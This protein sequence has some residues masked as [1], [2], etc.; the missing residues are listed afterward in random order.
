MN[1]HEAVQLT[2]ESLDRAIVIFDLDLRVLT[3]SEH[4]ETVDRGRLAVILGRKATPQAAEMIAAS[5]VRTSESPVLLAAH[6]DV[7]ARVVVPLRYK[8]R[9]YG[10]LTFSQP[11]AEHI[12]DISPEFM[13][14]LT[15]AATQLA[16]LVAV[17]TIADE[18]EVDFRQ[19]VMSDLLSSQA[20]ERTRGAESVKAFR[21][22]PEMSEYRVLSLQPVNAAGRD[23]AMLALETEEATR[24]V[25]R[26]TPF[27]SFGVA[28]QST[29][30]L[31]I[32][33]P[34][35]SHKIVTALKNLTLGVVVG[36]LGGA[37]SDLAELD[38]SLRESHIAIDSLIR[39][40]SSMRFL[41][42]WSDLGL[43]RLL[44]QLPLASLSVSDLPEGVAKLLENQSGIDLAHTLNA[45]LDFGGDAQA[46]AKDLHIHRS[47]FYYRLDK[48]REVTGLD[49]SDGVVR[50]EL[51]TGLRIA[52]LAGLW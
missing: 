32:A 22:L 13:G 17:R 26:A 33:G 39:D 45:Y 46:T 2:A 27:H 24:A 31:V 49:L 4:D 20:A 15:N 1:L 19:S 14:D 35:D 25:I 34:L 9:L 23:L 7:P 52:H 16:P 29:G 6:D 28:Q 48:I 18:D 12:G 43:D 21:L 11:G 44:L 47:T 51:H 30:T 50:R 36:G 40:T 41:A 38:S 8:G 10:F 3:F 37:T 5:K 42:D